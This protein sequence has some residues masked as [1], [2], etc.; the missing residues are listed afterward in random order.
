MPVS[1]CKLSD[2]VVP[3]PNDP[4]GEDLLQTSPVYEETQRCPTTELH[5]DL[6][7]HAGEEQLD[8]AANAV[9]VAEYG[10][11]E[12]LAENGRGG[13][14]EEVLREYAP[15]A[16]VPEGEKRRQGGGE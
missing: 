12:R 11:Q 4:L 9:A 8:G 16:L 3:C 15:H 6:G 7:L 10:L 5:D 1:G 13:L 14:E 2:A